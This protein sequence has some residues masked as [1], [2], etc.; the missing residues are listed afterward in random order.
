MGAGAGRVRE[1][2]GCL[3][4]VRSLVGRSHCGAALSR[5]IIVDDSDVIRARVRQALAPTGHEVLEA[6]DGLGGLALVRANPDVPLVITDQNMPGMDGTT[7]TRRIFDE[8]EGFGGTVLMLTTETSFELSGRGLGMEVVLVAATSL[9]GTVT[10]DT[11][12]GQGTTFTVTTP[13]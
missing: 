12:P 1:A 5:I 3:Q 10:V 2:P 7:L 11:K 8:V 6:A 13:L 9:G 4:S